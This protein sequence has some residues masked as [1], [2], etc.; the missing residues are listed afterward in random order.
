[1]MMSSSMSLQYSLFI[2]NSYIYK[3][4]EIISFIENKHEELLKLD[5]KILKI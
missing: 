4:D 1:M 2:L 3:I 5:N